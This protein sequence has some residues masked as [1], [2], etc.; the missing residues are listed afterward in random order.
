M[1]GKIFAAFVIVLA[2]LLG[3]HPAFAQLNG[4]GYS[5]YGIGDLLYYP[6]SRSAGMGGTDIALLPSNSI[7][8]INPANWT[9]ITL[10]RFSI[11]GI[12]R[13]I[14]TSDQ[15]TSGNFGSTLFNGV[16]FAMPVVPSHGIVTALSLS[17]YSNV[18]YTIITPSGENGYNY[19]LQFHGEGGLSRAQLGVSANLGWAINTGF[20]YNYYFGTLQNNITQTFTSGSY[21]NSE[22]IREVN[23]KGSGFTFGIV[24]AGLGNLLNLPE[25]TELHAGA[26]ISTTTY[27]AADEE[28]QTKSTDNNSNSTIDTLAM[29]SYHLKVPLRCGAGLAFTSDRFSLGSDIVLQNWNE[30]QYPGA[31]TATM[32]NTYRWSMGGE[33]IPRRESNAPFL[34]KLAY[35]LG[36]YYYTTYYVIHDQPIDEFGVTGGFSIPVLGETRIDITG[37]YGVRGTTDFNLQRDHLF[38]LSFTLTAGEAWFVRP[39][40]E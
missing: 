38:R 17:P 3:A 33:F 12:Y 34:Q 37:E 40:E 9:R 8:I 6:N 4:S 26:F 29:R 15:T 21:S 30:D 22:A 1:N 14:S 36:T 27:L 31:L 32:R 35:R 24:Y 7:D 39:P 19:D 2:I 25:R 11:S 10:T 13:R 28:R 18:G 23:L 5:R 20:S 16:T